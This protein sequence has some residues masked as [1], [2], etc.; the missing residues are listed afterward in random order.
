MARP[1]KSGCTVCNHSERARIE[2]LKAS[3]AS[4]DVLAVRFG[5][6]KDALWRHYK[7]HVSE[8]LKASYLAG[9]AT[10][11]ELRERAAQESMSVLDYLAIARSMIIGM[12]TSAAEA[13]DG[14]RVGALSS[15]LVEVL[16]EI[17]R[18]TGEV[19]KLGG[20]VNIT[21]NVAIFSDPRMVE[22]QTGLVRIAREHPDARPALLALLRGLD[23]KPAVQGVPQMIEGTA[24][25]A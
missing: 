5:V 3:G 21:N 17:G 18:I 8:Q 4:Y 19:D 15:R 23:S 22:L 1:S 25:V 6:S 20:G 24:H 12:M 10:I 13:G 16:R 14:F 2:A 9:K 11:A 7:N